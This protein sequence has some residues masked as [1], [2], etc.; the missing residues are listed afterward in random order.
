MVLGYLGTFKNP[1]VR[2]VVDVLFRELCTSFPKARLIELRVETD[3]AVTFKID[4]QY[5]SC[6][7]HR[8]DFLCRMA[9]IFK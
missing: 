9:A 6:L 8:F 3:F 4:E 1:A 5:S 7:T 2:Q